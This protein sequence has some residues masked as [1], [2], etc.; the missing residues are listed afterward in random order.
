M[1]RNRITFAWVGALV[2]GAGL[3]AGLARAED[4]KEGM[5]PVQKEIKQPFMD[6]IV[7]TWNLETS[8]TMAGK[9]KATFAKGV[10]GTAILEDLESKSATGP[11]FGHGIHKVSDDN[12]TVTVFWIDTHSA[13]PLKL[14]GPLTDAGYEISADVPNMGTMK[15]K[16][17]KK[18]DGLV[19]TMDAGGQTMVTNYTR[20]K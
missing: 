18:G 6:T 19:F 20:A 12:K 4:P 11:F 5:P 17:E 9:G 14:T 10:G 16:F 7:G 8:G 15:I 13:E 3:C 1:T 2:V